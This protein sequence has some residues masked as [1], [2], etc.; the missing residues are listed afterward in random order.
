MILALF[1]YVRY[2]HKGTGPVA[3]HTAFS[4]ETISNLIRTD[5]FLLFS[6][7]LSTSVVGLPTAWHLPLLSVTVLIAVGLRAPA[8]HA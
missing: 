3:H 8:P 6:D 5:V 7:I 2:C 4:S 1:R